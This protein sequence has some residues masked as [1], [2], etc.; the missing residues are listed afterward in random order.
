MTKFE[1]INQEVKNV[2]F[3]Q[4]CKKQFDKLIKVGKYP[5]GELTEDKIFE[6][7]IKLIIECKD[8]EKHQPYSDGL[9]LSTHDEEFYF[10]ILWVALV[11]NIGFSEFLDEKEQ[12]KLRRKLRVKFNI[13]E[14][15]ERD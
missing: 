11:E 14:S 9:E 3:L 10:K 7:L 6:L 1:L 13:I 15:K 5:S 8:K 2:L 4:E 12:E